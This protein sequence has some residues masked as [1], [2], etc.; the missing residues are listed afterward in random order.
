MNSEKYNK[1]MNLL[2][3]SEPELDSKEMIERAIMERISRK[4]QSGSITSRVSEFLFGWIYIGWVRS[5]LIGA[6]FMLLVFFVW[7]QNSIMNQI[8]YL[9][10]QIDNRVTTYNPSGALEKKLIFYRNRDRISI[11]GEDMDQLLDSLKNATLKYK[12]IMD[13]IEDD[14]VLKKAVE[15]KLKKNLGS[16]FN[17]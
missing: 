13:L 3:K 17:L 5:S 15:E 11:P 6:S 2:R 8:D 4:Y 10:K 1:L 12:E 16:K 14:P 7:Q 9:G